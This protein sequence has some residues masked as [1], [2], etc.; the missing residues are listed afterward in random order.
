METEELLFCHFLWLNAGAR[1]RGGGRLVRDET[2]KYT[3]DCLHFAAS[4]N[5]PS[6]N[7]PLSSLGGRILFV[8]PSHYFTVRG[9]DSHIHTQAL[10]QC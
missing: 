1:E 3:L 4:G 6:S 10:F 8:S 5:N 7:K 9:T 2:V